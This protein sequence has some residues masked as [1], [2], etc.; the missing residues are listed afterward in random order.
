M[1]NSELH[2]AAVAY[3]RGLQD[4]I[5]LG[6]QDA[7]GG[8]TFH[9]DSWEREGGGG[10]RSRVLVDGNVFEKAGVN[11]SEVFG[12]MS[13]EFAKQVPGE[14]AAFT[15]TGISLVLHPHNPHVPT[16]HANFRFLTKGSVGQAGSL[17][18]G[19]FG[20]GAD[21]T[22]YYPV[23]EDVVQFHRTWKSVCDR[24]T[25][26]V[27][28]AA[29][30]KD[31]DDYF[32]LPHRQEARGVGGIFFDFKS[33][34]LDGWFAFVNDAGDAFLSSYLPIV[35]RRKNTPSGERARQFQ[36]YRRG[37]YVEFNLLYDRGTVFGLKTGGRVE[38]ILMSLP[39]VVRYVYD[40]QPEPG[41]KEA[42]LT[43]YWLKPRD[44]TEMG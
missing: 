38:S 4:R 26:L 7:D 11:F 37:R 21:L 18:H 30:K 6:I 12:D 22:P 5:C 36:E 33:D 43:E 28:Y 17:S 10:G 25:P 19:W 32:F 34:D 31:C 14:G 3:F 27:D 29:L 9:E 16:V 40:Y 39:P 20:G 44:W 8:G 23:L 13:P 41:S 2:S 42:E 24:H 15:A 35:E 1:S